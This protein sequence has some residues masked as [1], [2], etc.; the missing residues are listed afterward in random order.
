MGN[1]IIEEKNMTRVSDIEYICATSPANYSGQAAIEINQNDQ[2]WQDIGRDVELFT[3]PRV[4]AVDPTFGVTKNPKGSKVHV[5]GENFE[6]NNGDCSHIKVR[7]T[8]K[9]GDRI[10]VAGEFVSSSQVNCQYPEYPSPETLDVD[11]SMNG[12]DWSGDQVKFAYVDPFV[13][14]VRPRLISPAGTTK[15]FVEGYGM[16]HTGD[17][18]KQRIAFKHYPDNK[19]LT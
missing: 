11:I 6:C 12:I 13:L 14:G 3:G 7:F 16:A 19:V 17:D 2:N 10:V 8:T 18:S 1:I 4:T 5:L 15:L 9:N